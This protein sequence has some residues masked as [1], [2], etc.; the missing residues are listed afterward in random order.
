MTEE[1]TNVAG[2]RQEENM[3]KDTEKH[4]SRPLGKQ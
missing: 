4:I 1:M 3:V 2:W